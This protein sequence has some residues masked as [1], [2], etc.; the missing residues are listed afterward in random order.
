[1][2]SDTAAACVISLP[3]RAIVQFQR[4]LVRL[5][6][7]PPSLA[8]SGD[9][10]IS[11]PPVAA[12][13]FHCHCRRSRC[14]VCQLC[15]FIAASCNGGGC[16][17]SLPPCAIGEFVAKAGSLQIRRRLVQLCN[18]NAKRGTCT[19]SLPPCAAEPTLC[20]LSIVQFH[21]RLAELSNF[22]AN[23][24]DGT[25]SLTPWAAGQFHCQCR[26]PPS[27]VCQLC[28]FIA[29]SSNSGGAASPPP[30]P[31]PQS[32]LPPPTALTVGK[33]KLAKKRSIWGP[34]EAQGDPKQT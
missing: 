8:N 12:G 24:G 15:N 17:I 27:A 14:A 3:A 1:M 16:A 32:P 25:I 33:P 7:S 31:L 19:I 23:G 34:A 21:F 28:N 11:L 26:R 13:Q 18:F 20:R 10:T 22:T 5:D 4:R 6:A 29:A 30:P 2:Q 9:C